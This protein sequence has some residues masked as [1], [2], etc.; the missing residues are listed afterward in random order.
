MNKAYGAYSAHVEI[1]AVLESRGI[2][3]DMKIRMVELVRHH[4][5]KG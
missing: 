1:A 3:W 5:C 2:V 4:K